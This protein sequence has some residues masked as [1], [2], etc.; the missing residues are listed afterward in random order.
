MIKKMSVRKRRS[1]VRGRGKKAQKNLT[2]SAYFRGSLQTLME[3]VFSASPHFVRYIEI[4]QPTN[5][6]LQHIALIKLSSK[7][8]YFTI[9][10]TNSDACSLIHQ[11]HQ[12]KHQ[13][14]AT[15]IW[16]WVCPEAV[17]VCGMVVLGI[18]KQSWIMF[19]NIHSSY[20]GMLEAVRVRKEGFSY[21]PFF[22]D[23]VSDY[24]SIAFKFTDQVSQGSLY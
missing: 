8:F 16:W 14:V 10:S 22:S 18:S 17:K 4:M 15:A 2:V 9:L 7:P 5:L 12:I 3:R 24:K 6:H 23:F 1:T 20:T 19:H 11:V 13:E 21:R